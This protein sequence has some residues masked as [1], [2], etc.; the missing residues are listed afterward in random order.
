MDHIEKNVCEVIEIVRRMK[1]CYAKGPQGR[2]EAYNICLQSGLNGAWALSLIASVE[3][4]CD[5]VYII[6]DICL[7]VI[8]TLENDIIG[9][10]DAKVSP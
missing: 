9:M 3:P 6:D 1:E 7:H 10:H 2:Y 8:D 4:V 5:H